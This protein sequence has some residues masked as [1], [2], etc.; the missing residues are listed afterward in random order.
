MTWMWLSVTVIL[1]GAEL[2]AEMEH[3]TVRDSTTGEPLPMGVRGARMAD[4]LGKAV[5]GAEK[6]EAEGWLSRLLPRARS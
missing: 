4:T 1:L 3:Q 2:S 5:P 6:K